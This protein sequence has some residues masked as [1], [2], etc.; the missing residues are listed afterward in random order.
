MRLL[1]T[2]TRSLI[3]PPSAALK[4]RPL[5]TPPFITSANTA[6]GHRNAFW[7]CIQI[8]V[9]SFSQPT[10]LMTETELRWHSARWPSWK[11]YKKM[12]Q[13]IIQ[14][15]KK[16]TN[17]KERHKYQT[18]VCQMVKLFFC[19]SCTMLG[20][21]QD[22]GLKHVHFDGFDNRIPSWLCPLAQTNPTRINV[23]YKHSTGCALASCHDLN[24][25]VYL[26]CTKYI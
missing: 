11:K 4:P 17:S 14:E 7:S 18:Q 24:N 13:F 1:P 12:K 15:Y 5:I 16:N 26:T 3:T 6:R 25:A 20:W 9:D 10:S 8:P 19:L 23:Q 22:S 21:L 2:S